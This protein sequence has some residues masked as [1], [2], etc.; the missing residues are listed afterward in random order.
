MTCVTGV[1]PK[2]RAGRRVGLLGGTF[3]P[4]HVGHLIMAEAVRDQVGL[5]EIHFVVANVPWQKEGTRPI[6]PAWQRLGLVEAAVADAPHLRCSDVEVRLG[7]P[8]YTSQTLAHLVG[9]DP[10]TEWHVVVGADVA[11]GLDTWHRPD[12]VRRLG[13]LIVVDRPGSVGHPPPGWEHR[14][15]EMPL[16]GISS[17]M[18]RA[19]VA[20]GRSVRFLTPSPVV[21]LI[22]RW[23]L[24]RRSG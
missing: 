18:I 1:P 8:S 11:E 3:D 4:P 16:V 9:Q 7:G 2:P 22:E 24:Y 21:A 5:D 15:V 23:Q 6:T 10:A 12:E 20:G 14:R 19:W 13:R 17:S